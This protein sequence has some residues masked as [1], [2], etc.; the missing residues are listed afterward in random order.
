MLHT[1]IQGKTVQ[2]EHEYFQHQLMNSFELL[3]QPSACA[4]LNG[5]KRSSDYYWKFLRFYHAVYNN[6]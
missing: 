2:K 5:A 1:C 4:D 6:L 3:C